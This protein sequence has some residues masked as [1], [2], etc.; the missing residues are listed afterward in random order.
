MTHVVSDGHLD[1]AQQIRGI[2]AAY[3][4]AEDLI[5]IGAYVNGSNPAIDRALKY[6]EPVQVFLRQAT[7]ETAGFNETLSLMRKIFSS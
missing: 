2:L 1:D 3:K 7:D 5:N 6:I 4:R